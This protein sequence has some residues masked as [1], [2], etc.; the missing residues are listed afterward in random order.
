LKDTIIESL[1]GQ[2]REYE[3]RTKKLEGVVKELREELSTFSKQQRSLS[4]TQQSPTLT[5]SP[6]ALSAPR[7]LYMS[8]TKSRSTTPDF[9]TPSRYLGGRALSP[10]DSDASS[11]SST[12]SA[13]REASSLKDLVTRIQSLNTII[14]A[15]A[16]TFSRCLH[17]NDHL[18]TVPDRRALDG[19]NECLVRSAWVVGER[20]ASELVSEPLP[21][22]EMMTHGSAC[23]VPQVL[24]QMVLEMVLAKWA[25]FVL[26]W[27][28]A[29]FVAIGGFECHLTESRD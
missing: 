21:V 8:P 28:E 19:V 1:T 10:K 12:S 6:L 23:Q 29:D 14:S 26:G 13:S 11:S 3:I 16:S 17:W 20:V 7:P 22:R 9:G 27:V 24:A 4:P 5:F 25:A 2:L 15:A 18:L